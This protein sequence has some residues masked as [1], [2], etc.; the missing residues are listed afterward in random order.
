MVNK[1]ITFIVKRFYYFVLCIIINQLKYIT[2][3][4]Y[5]TIKKFCFTFLHFFRLVCPVKVGV[6]E[7]IGN[8][9]AV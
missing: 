9:S 3:L 7:S 4:V 6:E 1:Q 5:N 8:P 2:F